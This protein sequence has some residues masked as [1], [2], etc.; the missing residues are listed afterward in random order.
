M[1]SE[2]NAKGIY[3]KSFDK[4]IMGIQ[5]MDLRDGILPAETLPIGLKGR[6]STK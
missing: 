6:A 5:L 1:S 2:K 3:R 4:E